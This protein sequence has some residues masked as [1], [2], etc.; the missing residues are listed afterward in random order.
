MSASDRERREQAAEAVSRLIAILHDEA[1]SNEILLRRNRFLDIEDLLADR[2]LTDSEALH[3]AAEHVR[4]IHQGGR[5]FTDFYLARPDFEEQRQLNTMFE[6][7]WTRL[8]DAVAD[9]EP[10]QTPAINIPGARKNLRAS[11]FRSWL[12]LLT[13]IGSAVLT[14]FLI[15]KSTNPGALLSF[16]TTFFGV[17]G[18]LGTVFGIT[19][20]RVH[21]RKSVSL[22]R[23]PWTA[24]PIT[25]IRTA[26]NEWV[27]LLSPNGKPVCSLLLSTWPHQLGKLINHQTPEIWFAG[28]PHRFGVIS[29]PGGTDL[30][31]AY[32]SRL[33]PPPQFTFRDNRHDTEP[34]E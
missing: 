17:V 34:P 33:Y 22:R 14:V 28:D 25:Y 13:G 21:R 4:A 19:A 24:W 12:L 20:M 1:R 29:R 18:I 10:I 16:G 3:A 7:E 27:T 5:S 15:N 32:F 26:R 30:R 2:E 11:A 8:W 9:P 31:Y 23:N 6:A